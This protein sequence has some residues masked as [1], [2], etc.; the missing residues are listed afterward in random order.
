MHS[1]C[2]TL[3]N[4]RRI[5]GSSIVQR[6]CFQGWKNPFMVGLSDDE[7][8]K[9]GLMLGSFSKEIDFEEGK[10]PSGSDDPTWHFTKRR[11]NGSSNDQTRWFEIQ[12]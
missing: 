7:K 11:T 10:F 12:M 2:P 6:S 5:L 4:A 9:V 3:Q 1:D 8:M